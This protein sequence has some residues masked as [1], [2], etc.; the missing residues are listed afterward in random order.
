MGFGVWGLG[1]GVW[2]LGFGVWGLGFEV[3]GL[4]FG[5]GGLGVWGW[6]LWAG[7]CGFWVW[8]LR[9]GGWVLG[10]SVP[11]SLFCVLG[12]GRRVPGSVFRVRDFEFRISGVGRLRQALSP[13]PLPSALPPSPLP[14]TRKIDIRLTGKGNSNSH[15][16]RPVYL[17][18]RMIEWFRTST[19]SIK[20]FS[21]RGRS[22]VTCM[23]REWLSPPG[24]PRRC[25][26]PGCRVWSRG[27]GCRV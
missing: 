21:F 3:W 15:G 24:S 8:G 1:S 27:V 13:E 12:V 20:N 5:V 26:H 14:L 22:R 4:G 16:A 9:S 10:V 2:G 25:R 17:I 11:C 6:G 23:H 7:D 19:L 18:I